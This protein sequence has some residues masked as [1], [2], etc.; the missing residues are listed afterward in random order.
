MRISS[1]RAQPERAQEDGAQE[2]ALAV[3]AHVQR[4]LLVVLELHPRSAIG[5]DLAQEVGAVVG[6]LEEDARRTVQLRNDHALGA[7]HDERAVRRH[8]RNVA[9]EDF[10]LLDVANG[11]V[12][13]LG[14]LV[15]NRQAHRDL[16]RGRERHAA[17]FALLLVVL[18][19]QADRVAA[20]VAEVGGVLVVVAALGAEHVAGQERVRDHHRSAVDAGGAQVVEPFQVAA[21]ALP[22]ADREIDEIQLRDAAEIG[23]RENGNKHGLQP[24]VIA[25][26]GQLVHLQKT[27]VRTALNFDQ[28]GN[29]RCCGNL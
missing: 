16:E 2:L 26:V 1:S 13:G 17:L 24:R 3:D 28:V 14:I 5:N 9:E 20:L 10:L 18:E 11:L 4:V 27:L 29:L 19:L 12:A 21:L 15:V 7:V 22:V 6:R 8:Q 23:N 25:L